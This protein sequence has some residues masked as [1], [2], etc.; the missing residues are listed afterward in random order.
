MEI[1]MSL[2]NWDEM[3]RNN[4]AQIKIPKSVTLVAVSKRKPVKSI[5]VAY[6]Y[7]VRDFGENYL[8]DA[9]PKIQALQDLPDIRWHYIGHIQSN[10]IKEIVKYFDMVQ[11]VDRKKVLLKMQNTCEMQEKTLRIL[12][13]I[14]IGKEPQKSGIFPENLAEFLQ[15]CEHYSRLEVQGLMGIPP[16]NCDPRPYFEEMHKLFQQ[17]KTEFGLTTLSMGMSHDYQ[18]AVESGATMVRIGTSIFGPRD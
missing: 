1:A 5:R 6:K 2:K 7:G 11:S 8:Q 13:Q 17:Y 14:N 4:L 9:I 18:L 15:E 12:I 3:I 10:K 16:V